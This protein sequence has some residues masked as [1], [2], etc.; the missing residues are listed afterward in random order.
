MH[1][2]AYPQLKTLLAVGG[3]KHENGPMSK[4][5]QMVKTPGNR[6]VFIDSSIKFLR[7]N[8]FDGFD[9]DWEYPG[10]RGNSPPEDK[11]QFSVLCEDLLQAFKLE[12]AASGRKRLLLT[13]A[14]AAGIGTI[15]KA[16]EISRIAKFLDWI[17]LMTYDFHGS[18]ESK[19]GHH[20]AM[21]GTRIFIM[22]YE[23]AT[24]AQNL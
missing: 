21:Q 10:N 14:V 16:Y 12:A 22:Y 9:L 11:Q 24:L 5:S 20:A 7:K 15:Q 18:W 17:N 23:R 19:T 8:G 1:F 4:F 13:A 3:W 2:Q 6:Q